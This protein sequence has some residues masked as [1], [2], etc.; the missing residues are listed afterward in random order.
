MIPVYRRELN[1][2]T[3]VSRHSHRAHNSRT[4]MHFYTATKTTNT[5]TNTNTENSVPFRQLDEGTSLY[6]GVL[7]RAK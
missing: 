3:N 1:H 2:S 4:R 6:Q 7:L 5:E